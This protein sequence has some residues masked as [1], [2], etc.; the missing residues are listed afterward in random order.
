[1]QPDEKYDIIKSLKQG[2]KFIY[3]NQYYMKLPEYVECYGEKANAINMS[4]A[5]LIY[6]NENTLID[7]DTMTI[8]T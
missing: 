5:T 1:M 3:N 2:Q 6:L 7:L 8:T 4:T